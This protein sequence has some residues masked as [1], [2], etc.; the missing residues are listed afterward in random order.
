[1]SEFIAPIKLGCFNY[2]LIGLFNRW[3]AFMKRRAQCILKRHSETALYFINAVWKSD[4]WQISNTS[5]W[6]SRQLRRPVFVLQY[7]ANGHLSF[8]TLLPLSTLEHRQVWVRATRLSRNCC[9]K[10]RLFSQGLLQP[11]EEL[12][13]PAWWSS[14]S[15]PW[16]SGWQYQMRKKV[17]MLTGP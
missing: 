13:W 17:D 8:S 1:M 2:R 7:E 6:V 11:S 12:A 10:C 3:M 5:P 15:L 4:Q 9:P 16:S 14:C